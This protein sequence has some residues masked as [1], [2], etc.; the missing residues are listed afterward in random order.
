M[1]VKDLIVPPVTTCTLTADLWEVRDLM[2]V[3]K[4]SAIP[5]VEIHGSTVKLRGIVTHYDLVGVVDDNVSIQQVMTTT[6]TVVSSDTSVKDAAKLMIEKKTHHLVVKDE[7]VKG[8][9][10]SFDFVKIV[11][12]SMD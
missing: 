1:K 2:N 5:V 6:V 7:E 3:K 12:E 9:I 11:A 10:S 8:I 4:I